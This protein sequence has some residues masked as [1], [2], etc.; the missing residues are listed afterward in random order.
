[1]SGHLNLEYS[2]VADFVNPDFLHLVF[3]RRLPSSWYTFSTHSGSFIPFDRC[4]HNTTLHRPE[5]GTSQ[6]VDGVG[7]S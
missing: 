3:V 4:R 5:Y 7:I 6:A 1:L 2:G